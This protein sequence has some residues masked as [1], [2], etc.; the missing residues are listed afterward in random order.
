MKNDGM[1]V[2]LAGSCVCLS[3]G[4][5]CR[6][7]SVRVLCLPREYAE[8]RA[9]L[10]ASRSQQEQ[11]YR[12]NRLFEGRHPASLSLFCAAATTQSAAAGL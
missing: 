10:C 4:A 8:V 6:F 7:H 9:R 12:E 1:C 2:T 3:A 11:I 5:L